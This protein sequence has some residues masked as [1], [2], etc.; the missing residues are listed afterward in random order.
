MVRSFERD[1][2][3]DKTKM[4]VFVCAQEEPSLYGFVSS[5]LYALRRSF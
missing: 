3:S 1:E 4:V 2:D 5:P